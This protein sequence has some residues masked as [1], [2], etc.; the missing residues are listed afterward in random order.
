MYGSRPGIRA[1]IVGPGIIETA[2]LGER[3]FYRR[4]FYS[5]HMLAESVEAG[6]DLDKQRQTQPLR[7][8]GTGLYS[9]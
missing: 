8:F 1:N 3:I 4:I 7:K 6:L 9:K 5:A 2:G